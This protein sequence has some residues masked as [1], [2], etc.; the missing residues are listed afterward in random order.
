MTGPSMVFTKQSKRSRIAL[1]G[2]RAELGM[3]VCSGCSSK[4]AGKRYVD[5]I[6]QTSGL[7]RHH[8]D[9]DARQVLTD[10]E[11]RVRAK[12]LIEAFAKSI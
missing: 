8:D 9:P 3:L 6:M 7:T 12:T 5:D 4:K 11:C 10:S 1:P 2:D